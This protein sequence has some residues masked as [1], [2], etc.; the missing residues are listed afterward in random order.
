MA[1]DLFFLLPRFFVCVFSG[2]R[3][4]LLAMCLGLL[5]V[6]GCAL[7]QRPPDIAAPTG[8][9]AQPADPKTS[10]GTKPAPSPLV[11]VQR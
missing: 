6:Q 7:L 11:P 10:V 9:P 1:S 8:T 2:R 4:C 3:P 5:L